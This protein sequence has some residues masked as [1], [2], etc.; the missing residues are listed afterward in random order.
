MLDQIDPATSEATVGG[1]VDF[2][3]PGE[4]LVTD[5]EEMGI[6]KLSAHETVERIGKTDGVGKGGFRDPFPIELII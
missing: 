3:L 2:G 6:I 5:M 1:L 4:G